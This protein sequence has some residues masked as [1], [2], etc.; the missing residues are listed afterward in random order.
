MRP[1]GVKVVGLNYTEFTWPPFRGLNTKDA[2][3]TSPAFFAQFATNVDFGALGAVRKAEGP[4]WLS[5]QISGN[6]K[7]L[8]VHEYKQND[9]TKYFLVYTSDGKLYSVDYGTEAVTL[10]DKATNGVTIASNAVGDWFTFNNLAIF[11]DGTNRPIYLYDTAVSA[12]LF[13]LGLTAPP[14][15][16]TAAVGSAGTMTGDYKYK[17]CFRS[18]TGAKSNLSAASGQASPASEQVD[19]TNI[20]VNPNTYENCDGSLAGDLKGYVEIY[21]TPDLAGGTVAEVYYYVDEVAEGTTVYT[22]DSVDSLLG[23]RA[24]EERETPTA[25]IK[26]FTE[27]NSSVYAFEPNSST[28]WYSKI[29]D[30]EAWGAFNYEYITP[31]D[32]GNITG[33]GALNFLNIFKDNAIHNWIGIPGLFR[34]VRKTKGIGALSHDSIKNVD[35]PGAGEVLVF[36]SRDG[37]YVY[38]EQ[39]PHSISREIENVFT[40]KDAST[41]LN[42]AQAHKA[43][44]EYS[45]KEKK[46]FLS[47]PVNGSSD[48][49]AL[50]IFDIPSRSWHIREPIYCGSLTLR[51]NTVGQRDV[52]AGTSQDDAT[53]GGYAFFVEEGDYYFAVG[54]YE[55][56]YRTVFSDCNYPHKKLGRYL[57]ID[58]VTQGDYNLIVEIYLD[59]SSIPSITRYAGLDEGGAVWDDDD[60]L[61]DS[62]YFAGTTFATQIVGLEKSEF[63]HIALGFRTEDGGQPWEVLSARL[64]YTPLPVAGQ[65]R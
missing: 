42:L 28:L 23:S 35:W 33:L 26:G 9:G 25:G 61:W 19:L 51:T 15:A 58:F 21:R 46:Y 64:R 27:Y 44:A 3:L 22:D 40:G 1:Q 12:R 43:S 54:D 14:S 55:S 16:C 36:L 24:V 11:G 37:V 17:T 8:A 50:L 48:N 65:R 53:Y 52:V 18:P 62:A 10:I 49:N 30:P 32:G 6:P 5:A 7:V 41:I 56:E 34:R 60:A 31:S 13:N 59:G 63:R 29:D 45:W 38:D 4:D 47:V 39:D 57:E 20:P 2:P